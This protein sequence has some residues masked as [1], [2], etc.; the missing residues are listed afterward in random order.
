MGLEGFYVPSRP[1]SVR[2]CLRKLKRHLVMVRMFVPPLPIFPFVI[3]MQFSEVAVR[4]VCFHDPLVVVNLFVAVV[5]VIVGVAGIVNAITVSGV[6]LAADDKNRRSYQNRSRQLFKT[7]WARLHSR[8][9][10]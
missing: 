6:R 1:A 7:K 9:S 3:V 5:T 10:F 4:P 2:T 8:C